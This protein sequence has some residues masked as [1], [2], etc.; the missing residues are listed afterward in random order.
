DANICE[1]GMHKSIADTDPDMEMVRR[2]CPACVNLAKGLRIIHAEDERTLKE[3]GG[4]KIPAEKMR[5][6][7]GRYLAMR[8]KA[9]SVTPVAE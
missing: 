1:C 7:D 9:P 5:P 4:D 2:R 3:L 6:E 8:M